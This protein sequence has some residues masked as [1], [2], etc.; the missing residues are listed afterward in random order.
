MGLLYLKN[1]VLWVKPFV[2]PMLNGLILD[3]ISVFEQRCIHL[4]LVS[5][6]KCSVE[7]VF[8]VAVW[9]VITRALGM[10]GDIEC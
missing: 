6:S 8:C 7:A 3:K 2:I 10:H 4:K 1:V 9:V 5:F